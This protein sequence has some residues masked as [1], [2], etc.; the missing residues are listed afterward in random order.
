MNDGEV[1]DTHT[2]ERRVLSQLVRRDFEIRVYSPAH[3]TPMCAR[4]RDV[5]TRNC[6]SEYRN[7]EMRTAATFRGRVGAV[8]VRAA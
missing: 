5:P 2:Y 4:E 3:V 8:G 1:N 7:D 6:A